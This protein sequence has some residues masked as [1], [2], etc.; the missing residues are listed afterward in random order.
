MSMRCRLVLPNAAR[1]RGR[2]RGRTGAR[3]SMCSV[4]AA[5]LHAVALGDA[6]PELGD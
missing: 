1:F 2:V 4:D 3:V 6:L 5:D